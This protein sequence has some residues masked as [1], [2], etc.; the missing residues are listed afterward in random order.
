MLNIKQSFLI[1]TIIWVRC[2][3]SNDVF[4][5]LNIKNSTKNIACF[6]YTCDVTDVCCTTGCAPKG[7]V[8]AGNVGYCPHGEVPHCILDKCCCRSNGD[9]CTDESSTCVEKRGEN[10]TWLYI[11]LWLAVALVALLCLIYGVGMRGIPC[12]YDI[13]YNYQDK[14][15]GVTPMVV[16]H[17]PQNAT[18]MTTI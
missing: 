18:M 14:N 15:N 11:F 7:S 17:T 12:M 8:C 10:D 16:P 4:C 3:K 13:W 9:T 1:I 5:A 2:V 6:N